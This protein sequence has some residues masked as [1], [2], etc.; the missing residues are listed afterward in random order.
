VKALNGLVNRGKSDKNF[1]VLKIYVFS[2]IEN[3]DTLDV[4]SNPM[5]NPNSPMI[6]PKIS[7]T[8]TFTNS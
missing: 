3:S 6:E 7:I 5:I 2:T 4:M 8:K 1:R